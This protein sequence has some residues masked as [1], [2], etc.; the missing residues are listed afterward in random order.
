MF[1][2]SDRLSY[3]KVQDG[4]FNDFYCFIP[5]LVFHNGHRGRHQDTR[6]NKQI[7]PF[8]LSMRFGFDFGEFG[9]VN[10]QTNQSDQRY[11]QRPTE[12]REFV[13]PPAQWRMRIIV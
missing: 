1:F 6:E 5:A 9:L 7:E 3:E 13:S 4:Q 2:R 10:Q 8:R 12:V 11:Y